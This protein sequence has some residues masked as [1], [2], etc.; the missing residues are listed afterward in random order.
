MMPRCYLRALAKYLGAQ[1]S[2]EQREDD[3]FSQTAPKGV[4]CRA[5]ISWS[6]AGASVHGWYLRDLS[7]EWAN[8]RWYSSRCSDS[9]A[10]LPATYLTELRRAVWWLQNRITKGSSGIVAAEGRVAFLGRGDGHFANKVF[11][12][13]VP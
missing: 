3:L 13:A 8:F 4:P 12:P 5:T 2:K 9:K 6:S 11:I 1:I 10:R 7:S